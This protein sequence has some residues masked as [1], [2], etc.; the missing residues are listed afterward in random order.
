MAA[1]SGLAAWCGMGKAEVRP[2]PDYPAIYM[3]ARQESDYVW[4]V[5]ATYRG[6]MTANE[7]RRLEKS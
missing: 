5:T 4:L 3:A 2:I 1:L 7:C 6:L